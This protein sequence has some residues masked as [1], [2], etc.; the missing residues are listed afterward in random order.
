MTSQGQLEMLTQVGRVRVRM[1]LWDKGTGGS[2]GRAECLG[3][4]FCGGR[5]EAVRMACRLLEL[6]VEEQQYHVDY[7]FHPCY[8]LLEAM[9]REEEMA[10]R[11]QR[12][13]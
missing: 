2:I 8:S 11:T 7:Q 9:K 13:K 12:C 3:W 10:F 4:R 1:P 6:R 5:G